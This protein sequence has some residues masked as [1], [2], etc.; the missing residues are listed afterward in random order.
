MK[1]KTLPRKNKSKFTCETCEYPAHKIELD[2]CPLC[3]ECEECKETVRKC[4]C[5]PVEA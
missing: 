2:H 1:K 3:K 4:K 5:I